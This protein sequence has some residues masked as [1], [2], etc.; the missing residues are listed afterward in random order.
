MDFLETAGC[1][2]APLLIGFCRHVGKSAYV[3]DATL[4]DWRCVGSLTEWP[5]G[6]SSRPSSNSPGPVAA[7]PAR[8]PAG[9][10]ISTRGRARSSSSS[11]R[12][13][14]VDEVSPRRALATPRKTEG[15]QDEDRHSIARLAMYPRHAYRTPTSVRSRGSRGSRGCSSTS[16]R[17]WCSPPTVGRTR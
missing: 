16:Q 7:P 8:R 2:F 5:G 13:G 17:I 1:Y 14:L 9:S 15:G 3:V 4:L 12:P 10:R 11:A 6:G